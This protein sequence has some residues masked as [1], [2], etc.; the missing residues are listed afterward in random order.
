M[1]RYLKFA[2][3]TAAASLLLLFGAAVVVHSGVDPNDYKGDII[4]LA[5]EKHRRTLA[6]PDTIKL[7]LY[8]RVGAD[9]GRVRLSESGSATEF[10]AVDSARISVALIPL[11]L[12]QE[13]V[14]DRI[15][16]RGMRARVIRSAD[17]SM[18][19]GDLTSAQ[20]NGPYTVPPDHGHAPLRVAV[21][22]IRIDN[23]HIGFDDR[24]T[25]RTLDVSHLHIDS[26]A[27][28][29]GVQSKVAMSASI[30]TRNPG[31]TTAITLTSQF[32]PDRARRRIAFTDLEANLDL[33]LRDAK[34][35]V[36]GKLD[37]DFDQ[38][39][40]AAI[41]DGTLDDSTFNVKAG[42][43]DHE[44]NLTLNVDQLD[45]NRYSDIPTGASSPAT[46]YDL[47][48]LSTLRATGGIEIG[49]LKAGPLE[50]SNVRAALRSGAGKLILQPIAADAYGGQLLGALTFDFSASAST[51]RI[52]VRQDL[53]GIQAAPLLT[54]LIGKAPVD[55]RGDAMVDINTTG[56]TAVQMREALSGVSS[57]RLANGAL[58]GID[59]ASMLRNAKSD[60]GLAGH[61]ASTPFTHL[62]GSF[63]IANGV[64][65]SADLVANAPR[66][67]LAGAGEIDLARRQ[68]DY[69]LASTPGDGSAPLP[70]RLTGPWEA[71]VWQVD[72]KAV[73][74][75][76]VK[77]K[78]RDKL[79]KTI[80]GIL[81]R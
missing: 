67:A 18:N 8:P 25:G 68:I 66:L 24:K 2:A 62:A 13:V 21:D 71:I 30:R 19:T 48:S 16:L 10:A 40:F 34:A 41:L 81:K 65:I 58:H 32:V 69:T 57:V 3:L 56:T 50:A 63:T 38:D 28:A 47:S 55:G 54:A 75:A 72:S 33:S 61:G 59:I 76:A 44:W 74:A 73:S 15:E 53:K 23:A 78:A 14:I 42:L 20:F 22:S 70:V 39:E 51:P 5:Q 12:H 64:A 60:Q 80:R 79:K 29:A 52:S 77:A 1:S 37:V 36:K 43:R 11:L 46:V 45:L 7:T 9:L 4:R 6:L 49:S 31:V 35:R 17:G 26:G 27:I